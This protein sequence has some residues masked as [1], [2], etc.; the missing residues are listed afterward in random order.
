MNL[1]MEVQVLSRAQFRKLQENTHTGQLAQLV[2]ASGLHPGGHR[3][4]PCIAHQD[5][6]LVEFLAKSAKIQSIAA[7]LAK[8]VTAH[9]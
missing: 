8:L 3:S 4:E 9:V 6:L 7:K 2:R 5:R 1:F